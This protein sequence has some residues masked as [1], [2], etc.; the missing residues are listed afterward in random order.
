MQNSVARQVLYDNWTNNFQADKPNIAD[1]EDKHFWIFEH[2]EL[3]NC[4]DS[5]LDMNS[6]FLSQLDKR[7]YL[8]VE[9]SQRDFGKVRGRYQHLFSK[10]HFVRLINE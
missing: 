6:L 10:W 5:F 3:T 9:R 7:L 8:G 2:P 1:R 4:R